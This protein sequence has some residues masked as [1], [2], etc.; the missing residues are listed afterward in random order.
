GSE[1]RLYRR[2]G[3]HGAGS[4]DGEAGESL[5]RVSGQRGA[6]GQGGA[7]G[8]VPPL[9]ARPSRVGGHGWSGRLPHLPDLSG[10]GE[11]TP[12]PESGSASSGGEIGLKIGL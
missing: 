9:P 12:R 6:H 5:R 11:S 7:R 4:G 1:R 10:G 3:Q 8:L 2:L